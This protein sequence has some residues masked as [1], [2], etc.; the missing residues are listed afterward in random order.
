[1]NADIET[2]VAVT[3]WRG[4]LDPEARRYFDAEVAKGWSET[5]AHN[6]HER[7]RD[8]LGIWLGFTI[9]LVAIAATIVLVLG[10]DGETAVAVVLGGTTVVA[11]ATIFA[12]RL[13]PASPHHESAIESI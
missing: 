1:M 2:L 4:S 6:A 3:E 10:L 13:R 8:I 5:L 12:L 11:L 9:A 7:R